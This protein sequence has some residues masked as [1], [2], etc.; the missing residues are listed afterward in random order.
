MDTDLLAGSESNVT[1][2][3]KRLQRINEVLMKRKEKTQEKGQEVDMETSTSPSFIP[4]LLKESQLNQSLEQTLL[5]VT[6]HTEGKPVALLGL[7][8]CGNL[9][10]MLLNLFLKMQQAALLVGIG[11]C[12][13]TYVEGTVTLIRFLNCCR[14]WEDGSFELH[15][16]IPYQ[17]S[18]F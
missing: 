17:Q 6:V 3:E 4:L 5:P 10:V 12:Y 11:C 18:I 14:E 8:T 7:H 9:N 1:K 16:I 2:G 13:H 15:Q